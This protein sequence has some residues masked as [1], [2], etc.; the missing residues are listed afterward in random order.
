MEGGGGGVND[1]GC[2]VLSGSE[3]WSGGG[4]G[5]GVAGGEH[6]EDMICTVEVGGGGGDG[7]GDGSGRR[8]AGTRLCT[9]LLHAHLS[10]LLDHTPR[11]RVQA[12]WSLL[13]YS[14]IPHRSH[15]VKL[16]AAL[17]RYRRDLASFGLEFTSVSK[18]QYV[19]EA[20]RDTHA[21][22][23]DGSSIRSMFC[24]Q[25]GATYD[26]YDG[27]YPTGTVMRVCLPCHDLIRGDLCRLRR[28]AH[29]VQNP[30]R[31]R[32]T[33]TSGALDKS[34][35]RRDFMSRAQLELRHKAVSTSRN[36]RI[37]KIWHRNRMLQRTRLAIDVLQA[38]VH[39]TLARASNWPKFVQ[40]IVK[41]GE[42]GLFDNQVFLGELMNGFAV[43]LLH[44]RQHHIM[45]KNEKMFYCLLR[46]Y[47]GP[48]VHNLVSNNLLVR[49]WCVKV[50]CVCGVVRFVLI[51]ADHIS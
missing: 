19:V 37:A 4:G 34:K 16:A 6:Q 47:G 2:C 45:T 29:E 25:V 32:S 3:G 26:L 33:C 13:A 1:S 8:D 15:A 36:R 23:S 18:T 27:T 41:A 24:E 5:G 30:R 11:G 35:C 48:F 21:W 43:S 7:D 51:V 28:L 12:S 50:L 17:A 10:P 20:C 39:S 31:P 46:N 14:K 49:M 44:G 22:E 42:A 38:K 40:N 9:G